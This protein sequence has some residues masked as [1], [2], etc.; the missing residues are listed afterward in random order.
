MKDRIVSISQPYIRLIVRGKAK[1]LVELGIKIDLSFNENGME[2]IE[3]ITIDPNYESETLSE[4][5]ENC[6]GK[7]GHAVYSLHFSRYCSG[8]RQ[9]V[10]II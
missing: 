8:Q 7:T 3:K 1:S 2:R 5:G 9:P 10:P 4:A 6:R